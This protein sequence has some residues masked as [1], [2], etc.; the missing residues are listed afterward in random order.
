MTGLQPWGYES[1]HIVRSGGSRGAVDPLDQPD[2][3]S[4]PRASW[5]SEIKGASGVNLIAGIWLAM[6]PFVLAYRTTDP[7]WTQVAAGAVVALLALVRIT[8]GAWE[9]WMSWANAAL[10]AGICLLAIVV[11]DSAAAHWNGIAA[12]AIVLVLA[13]LSASATESAKRSS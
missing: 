4:V 13:A 12:G 8:R 1:S 9:S 3:A 6:S 2:P 11:A 7:V 10:S 5:R